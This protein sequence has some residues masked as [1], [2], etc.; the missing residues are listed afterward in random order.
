MGNKESRTGGH[1]GERLRKHRETKGWSLREV[2][3]RAGV[4]HGYLSLLERGEVAEPAPS[5]LHKLAPGYDLPFIVLMRW[6]GY[7]EPDDKELTKNQAIALSYLGD[8]ISDNE[9]AAVK[10]V[11]NAIRSKGGSFGLMEGS[12]DRQLT[13]ER[14]LEISKEAIH[15]LRRADCLHVVPTPLTQVMQVSRLVAVGEVT[16]AEEDRRKL[17]ARFGSLIDLALA[18]LQGAIHLGT[19]EVWVQPAMHELRKRFVTA[20]E[21]GHDML[22]WQRDAI[23]YL[24]DA[25][26]LCPDVRI[27]FEREANQ[28]AIEL[29]AQGNMLNKEA[30]DSQ[31]TA[32]MLSELSS[33]Y[34]ISL[35]AVFR[36]AIEGS[37]QQ[38]AVLIQFRS[39]G[40]LGRTHLYSSATF[41]SR[42]RWGL[43]G[44]P[45]EVRETAR[46]Q[47]G[48]CRVPDCSGAFAELTVEVLDTPYAFL[49]L[50]VP[51]KIA[52]RQAMLRAG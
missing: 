39:G 21:I 18:R 7:V 33:K 9:L 47:L 37:K 4:N 46:A 50:I 48:G 10:A 31:L 23:A 11:L 3:A 19:R 13:P 22:P 38:G 40:R 6:A 32:D 17:R 42:F 25:E 8:N 1:L 30:D 51:R 36:R 43:S 28:A 27:D 49:V 44:V 15:L 2:A 29:L 12:L 24:D 14:Q 35:Q 34:Q 41:E 26:R 45:S 16:L 52:K 20:H 5:M